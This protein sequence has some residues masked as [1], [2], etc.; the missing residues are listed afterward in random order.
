MKF[1]KVDSDV[2]EFRQGKLPVMLFVLLGQLEVYITLT[3]SKLYPYSVK[4]NETDF[5]STIE[6][7]GEL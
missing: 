2:I 1:Y 4:M 5:L 7:A 6:L 3:G